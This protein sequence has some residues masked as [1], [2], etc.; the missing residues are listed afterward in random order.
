MYLYFYFIRLHICWVYTKITKY[1]SESN[2]ANQN[3]FY[4]QPHRDAY[5][6][7][8]TSKTHEHHSTKSSSLSSLYRYPYWHQ[9]HVPNQ[10]FAESL[11]LN[12]GPQRLIRHASDENSPLNLQSQFLYANINQNYNSKLSQ[13]NET[14]VFDGGEPLAKKAKQNIN[15][16]VSDINRT[17]QESG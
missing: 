13:V 7:S 3:Y 5:D 10:H 15:P 2:A 8:L 6:V 12:I 17:W 9:G 16:S 11:P 1:F 14:R 4:P